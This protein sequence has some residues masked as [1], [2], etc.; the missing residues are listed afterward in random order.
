MWSAPGAVTAT[1]ASTTAST[2]APAVS[3]ARTSAPAA[4]VIH[5]PG[6]PPSASAERVAGRAVPS[7]LRERFL[8]LVHVNVSLL[9]SLT[10]DTPHL[11]RAAIRSDRCDRRPAGV[12]W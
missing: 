10:T 12:R 9:L 4:G 3:A 7:L 8:V 6:T 1:T 2:T 5:S 11:E